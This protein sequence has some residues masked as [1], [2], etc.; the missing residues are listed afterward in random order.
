ME[1]LLERATRIAVEAHKGQV[2]KA[3]G[4]PYIIHPFMVAL[5]L[6]KYHFPDTVVAAALVHDVL[7]DTNFSPETLQK[8]L[9]K[10]V[11]TI[12]QAVTHNDTLP[13]K[14]KKKQYIASVRRGPEGAKAVATADK[15]HNLESLLLAY[16][17]QGPS[18]WKKFN[19]GREEKLWFEEA[20]LQMLQETWDHPLV[21]EYEKLLQQEK[22]LP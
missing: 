14:E 8:E 6:A 7:E 20:M 15:I 11:F 12:V 18:L 21:E 17:Q 3:D 19:R 2:R 4:L 10:E 9:G 5:K 1:T 22:R 16:Q 13:W